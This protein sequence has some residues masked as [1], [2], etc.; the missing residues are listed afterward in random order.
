MPNNVKMPMNSACEYTNLMD[1]DDSGNRT[2][3]ISGTHSCLWSQQATKTRKKVT[4]ERF[5]QRKS[6]QLDMKL[7]SDAIQDEYSV[8]N[9]FVKART[10]NCG[11]G[12]RGE[13]TAVTDHRQE[14]QINKINKQ[15]HKYLDKCCVRLFGCMPFIE[16]NILLLLEK[17]N[18]VLGVLFFVL[19]FYV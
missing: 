11:L 1:Q 18:F 2:M 5:I 3:K 4:Q 15:G 7:R 14:E 16:R 10:D 9:T 6:K 19:F 12:P 8:K 17:R 13:L